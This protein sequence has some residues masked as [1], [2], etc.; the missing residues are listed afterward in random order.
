LRLL[1]LFGR[2]DAPPA[3]V[4]SATFPITCEVHRKEKTSKKIRPATFPEE[5][6]DV[7]QA[8]T[9]EI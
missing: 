3:S 7:A 8:V 9:K 4:A 2:D 6:E 1:I 5:Q